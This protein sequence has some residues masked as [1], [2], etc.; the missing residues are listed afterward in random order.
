MIIFNEVE[1]RDQLRLIREESIFLRDRSDPFGLTD[2]RF[3]N[4]F[5]LNKELVQFIFQELQPLMDDAVRISRISYQN[6]ILTALRFF[7]TGTY[8]RGVGQEYLLSI[9][10]PTVSKCVDE[11]SQAIQNH[12]GHE[13]IKFPNEN[14]MATNKTA[15]FEYCGMPGVIGAIDCTHVRIIAP[16]AEAHNFLNRKGYYSKNVQLICDTNLL[17]LNVNANFPGSTHDS[18]IWRQSAINTHLQNAFENGQRNTWLLGDSGYPLQP[19][20]LT[21]FQGPAPDSP[22]ER[23]NTAHIRGRNHIERVNGVLKA[24]FRCVSGERGLRYNPEKVGT[25]VNVCCVLHNMCVKAR[26]PIQDEP[27]IEEN[28]EE[29]QMFPVQNVLNEGRNIRN[30]IINLYFNNH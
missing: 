6:R 27:I 1:R 11:V 18:F 23:Y 5:R 8:Q 13:W 9:S 12:F 24:R 21:P 2:K 7:A 28:D 29:F 17:I 25:I 19:W 10:Q 26:V 30:N 14:D 15:F 4:L 20:L 22:E 3:I 16:N